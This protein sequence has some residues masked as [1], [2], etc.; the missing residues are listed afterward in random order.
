ML[1]NNFYPNRL[2]HLW[3]ALPIIDSSRQHQPKSFYDNFYIYI[4]LATGPV[5]YGQ[6]LHTYK[7]NPC[8]YSVCMTYS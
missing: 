1:T 7:I 6:S 3:N 2:S 8:T 5:V 4:I